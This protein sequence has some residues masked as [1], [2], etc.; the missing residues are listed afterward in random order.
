MPAIGFAVV[1]YGRMGRRH[2]SLIESHPEA[3]LMAVVDVEAGG[4]G[5]F[6]SLEALLDAPISA[7][8]QVVNITSPNGFHAAQACTALEKGKHV[9]VEKPF[10]LTS[11]DAEKV[12]S[13]AETAGRQVFVVMQNRYAAPARW[14]KQLLNAGD[15]GNIRLVQLNAFWNR[16]E[17][18]YHPGGWHGTRVLDGGVLFTQFSH[19]VDMLYWLCGDV[20]GIKSRF[21]NLS[22]Q[23]LTE[24]DDS[25]LVHFGLEGG[26]MGSFQF[27]TAVWEKNLESSITVIGEKGTVRIGGQYME[28][29]E[30][31]RL[32]GG[33][34]PPPPMDNDPDANHKMLIENVI[35]VLRGRGTRD[36]DPRDGLKV[37]D[38]I[39]RMYK[40]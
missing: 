27:S 36:I 12:L 35:N 4:A 26:G 17:R 30:Y 7:E 21:G 6:H 39:E 32:E 20:D 34:S 8:V 11:R 25:G 13:A 14:L 9:V 18:Y 10:A 40:S 29:V 3:R 31:C 23:K 19:F 2:A 22:H 28:R 1:G 37:I 24:F 5:F 33:Q 16:D 15:L 38:I